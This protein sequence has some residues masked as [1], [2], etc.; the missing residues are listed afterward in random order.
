MRPPYDAAFQAR[1][2]FGRFVWSQEA[3]NHM[4]P[5]SPEA[6]TGRVYQSVVKV[7][8]LPKR[9]EGRRA[10]IFV[11][12]AAWST[13]AR[14]RGIAQPKLFVC[15]GRALGSKLATELGGRVARGQT[16]QVLGRT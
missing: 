13:G 16:L 14:R 2:M 11:R 1:R 4:Y 6:S 15:L 5:G 3:P 12:V 9:F 10:S 8:F 7:G